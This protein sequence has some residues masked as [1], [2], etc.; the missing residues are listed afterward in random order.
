MTASLFPAAPLLLVDDEAAWLRSLTMTL[1]KDAG[2]NHVVKCEDSLK[3]MELLA[4]QTFSLVLLDLT[5]PQLSGEELLPRMVN[6]H[7]DVPVIIVSGVNQVDAAVRCMRAGARDYFI[8]SDETE[9]LIVSIQR[10]L[11]YQRL[12]H[13]N[14]RLKSCVLHDRVEDPAAFAS[15]VTRSRKM[16]ALFRY[17]EA[18]AP[19]PEPLLIT[20]ESGVGKE[21]IVRAAHE[22]RG[23]EGPLVAMNVA[24]LDDNVFSDTLFGHA[25]GAYTGAEQMRAG[26][27]AEAGSG[28]LF[29]DEIGDLSA[30]S[31]VKLLRLLQEGEYYPL[32][33]DRPRKLQARVVVAT[34][35]D[36][37][38]KQ[39]ADQFRKDL[40]Y[41]LC[42]HHV[43]VPPL[44]ERRED[45]PLLL[46]HFLA[47]AAAAMGKKKPTPPAELTVL[48]GTYAFPGNIRE[49]RAMAY[50]A[51]SLHQSGKLSMDSFKRTLKVEG[52]QRLCE[53]C[54][55]P[56]PA[57]SCGIRFPER[58]PTMAECNE[59]LVEEAMKRSRGNQ[60]VASGLLGISRQ[61]LSKRLKK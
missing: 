59:L 42:A 54:A 40:Y 56:A 25:K 45:I 4:S 13:E 19:S 21:L 28:T 37:G 60:T 7:P 12:Q 17:V 18:V 14:R 24:G 3:V 34:N 16:Q 38:Q 50:D 35:A 6:E 10:A 52:E 51:V 36:L 1:R 61:A 9:R 27:I 46:D 26:M 22:L 23:A 49:L 33:S 11:E 47:E 2:I 30:A 43:H 48:L 5:M 53:P 32:G 44:R 57:A 55:D 15:I 41:R 39:S 29:L 8:K 31:Q 58:L 20:G